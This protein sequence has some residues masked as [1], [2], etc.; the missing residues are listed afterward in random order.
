VKINREWLLQS[1]EYVLARQ[2]SIKS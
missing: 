1:L 2:E